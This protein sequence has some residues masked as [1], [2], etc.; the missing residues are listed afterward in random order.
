MKYYALFLFSAHIA[1]ALPSPS[2]LELDQ[3]A[4]RHWTDKGSWGHNYVEQYD[5]FFAP[6]RNKP[7]K[8]LE[9]GFYRGSSAYL[10]EEYFPNA[11]LHHLDIDRS[12]FEFAKKLSRRSKLHMVDQSSPEELEAFVQ[13]IGGDFDII[14]D[15]GSHVV[16][17]Q[18]TSFKTLFPYLKSGGI[19]VIEDLFSSYWKEYGGGGSKR[20]PKE[21]AG[22]TTLFLKALI[23]DLNW[24]GAKNA[25]ANMAVCP[26]EILDTFNYYQRNIQSMHFYTNI[27]FIVKR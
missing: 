2:S 16:S 3:I 10:W 18:I 25:Y 1:C 17:H 15:D 14:I 23:N 4:H 26:S 24:T 20:D 9:I 12:Q 11:T 8:F 5:F 27:C 22:S 13:Q 19:Y 7:L 6:L 21:S